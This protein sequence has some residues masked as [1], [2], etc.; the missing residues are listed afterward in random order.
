MPIF[1]LL[2]TKNA[3]LN[4]W[5][6]FVLHVAK[7]PN[8]KCPGTIV[9]FCA[10]FRLKTNYNNNQTYAIN[11]PS[12]FLILISACSLKH[13]Y[14]HQRQV[15]L[16]SFVLQ[17]TMAMGDIS[18]DELLLTGVP[19]DALGDEQVDEDLPSEGT[20]NKE[21]EISKYIQLS[22][23][24]KR[25]RSCVSSRRQKVVCN[26]LKVVFDCFSSG[27]AACHENQARFCVPEMRT[28]QCGEIITVGCK[29]GKKK[30]LK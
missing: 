12:Q 4:L 21:P 11:F 17:V 7:K 30:L 15:V 6:K 9:D 14:L 3:M 26:E 22:E 29:C 19:A 27:Q 10:Y 23:L 28:T 20:G 25:R 1:R 8:H 24:F 5:T 2:G 16:I 13:T 18:N